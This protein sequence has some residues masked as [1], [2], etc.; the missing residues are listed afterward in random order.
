MQAVRD[1]LIAVNFDMNHYHEESFAAPLFEEADVSSTIEDTVLDEA[2]P[3]RVNFS[4]TGKSTESN[5]SETLLQAAKDA[6]LNL[7]SAC[8]FGVCGTCKVKVVSGET[9]MVHNGGIRDTEI[10]DGYVLA[11]CTRPVSDV[12]LLL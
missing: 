9:H 3:A 11:C 10:E 2:I 4:L 1:V 7:P 5:Q 12:T 8:N 6:G